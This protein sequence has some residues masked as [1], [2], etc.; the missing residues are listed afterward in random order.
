[1]ATFCLVFNNSVNETICQYNMPG[2][3][4]NE[5]KETYIDEGEHIVGVYG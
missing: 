2:N 1:M 5:P 4:E 3:L